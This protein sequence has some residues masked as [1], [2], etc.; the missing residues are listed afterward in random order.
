MSLTS[1][2]DRQNAK[3]RRER[4]LLLLLVVGLSFAQFLRVGVA[5]ESPVAARADETT[6]EDLPQQNTSSPKVTRARLKAPATSF[7]TSLPN[8]P[9]NIPASIREASISDQD[10]VDAIIASLAQIGERPE[11][12]LKKAIDD[13]DQLLGLGIALA[14]R[15]SGLPLSGTFQNQLLENLNSSSSQMLRE[16][17]LEVIGLLP[18]SGPILRQTVRKLAFE[19]NDKIRFRSLSALRRLKDSSLESTLIAFAALRDPSDRIMLSAIRLLPEVGPWAGSPILHKN[20]SE[21]QTRDALLSSQLDS[22][23]LDDDTHGIIMKNLRFGSPELKAKAAMKLPDLGDF[24]AETLSALGD[25]L[26]DADPRVRF[27]AG[28][29]LGKSGALGVPTILRVAQQKDAKVR[30]SALQALAACPIDIPIVRNAI[31]DIFAKETDPRVQFQVALLMLEIHPDS[32]KAQQ[33]LIEELP[34]AHTELREHIVG[35]LQFSDRESLLKQLKETNVS[36]NSSLQKEAA[37]LLQL[38]A[39]KEG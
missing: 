26:A 13:N 21:I 33:I 4:G 29:A 20:F 32:A 15:S 23:E 19:K 11:A 3:L 34:F 18:Q 7:D 24:Q 31:E 36:Q 39:P 17:T 6:K 37:A 22:L 2:S 30:L 25:L 14:L 1:P 5:H 12:L 28:F 27:A 8:A 16:N 35:K 10:E 38:L 9:E